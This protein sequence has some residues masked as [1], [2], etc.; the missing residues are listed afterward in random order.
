MQLQDA[1]LFRDKAYIDGAWAAADGGAATATATPKRR[2]SL[3]MAW[4]PY[5]LTAALL[6]V[7]RVWSPLQSFLTSNLIVAW[8]DIFGYQGLSGSFRTLYLPGAIFV[9][10]SVFTRVDWEVG[11]V[12][13]VVREHIL[14]S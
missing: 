2:M 12:L 8:T 11:M 10:V 4:L 9:V 6:V 7:T 14:H 5:L 1:S 13:A 3:G